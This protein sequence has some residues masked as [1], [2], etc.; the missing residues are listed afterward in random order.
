MNLEHLGLHD[1][2]LQVCEDV[3]SKSDV[4]AGTVRAADRL[5]LEKRYMI[6]CC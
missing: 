3:L 2:A 1:D 5:A 6:T 4:T